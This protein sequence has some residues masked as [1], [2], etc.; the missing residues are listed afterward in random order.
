MSADREAGVTV[1]RVEFTLPVLEAS[2]RGA[3]NVELWSLEPSRGDGW[4]RRSPLTWTVEGRMLTLTDGSAWAPGTI[5]HLRLAGQGLRPPLL[6]S[7]GEPLSGRLTA[8]NPPPG[9]GRDAVFSGRV[10]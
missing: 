6:S 4:R 5:Y 8:P 3:D 2:L 10:P 9:R 7:C 1:L